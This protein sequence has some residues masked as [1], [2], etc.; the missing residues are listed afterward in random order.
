MSVDNKAEDIKESLL[1]KEHVSETLTGKQ[2]N[3][4]IDLCEERHKLKETPIE[5]TWP[6]LKYCFCCCKKRKPSFKFALKRAIRR[7]LEIKVPK[8]D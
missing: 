5:I 1:N 6:C 2:I 8:N 3:Y 4:A 7:K